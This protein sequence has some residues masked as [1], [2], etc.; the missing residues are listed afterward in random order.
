MRVLIAPN[1][2]KNSLSAEEVA[3]VIKEG[4]VASPLDV[5]CICFPVG[6]GGDGTGKLLSYHLNAKWIQAEVADPLGRKITSGFG[7]VHQDKT[8]IIELAEA[9]GLKLLRPEELDPTKATTFG[10]GQLIKKALDLNARKVLLTLGGSA[11]IDGGAGILNALGAKFLDENNESIH[12]RPESFGRLKT[13]DLSS[14]DDRLRK[15]E[16]QI[17]AD[18]N[19]PITG[20]N[21]A[22]RI[23]GPQKGVR[24]DQLEQFESN[25]ERFVGL[26]EQITKTTISG[27]RGGGAA[28][29]VAGVLSAVMNGKIQSGSEA[30]LKLTNFEKVLKTVDVVITGEG[31]LDLQTFDG[32]APFAVAKLAEKNKVPVIGVAGRVAIE[33]M[34]P[35]FALFSIQKGPGDIEVA[36]AA[37][38]ENLLACSLNIG[39]LLAM[40]PKRRRSR[41]KA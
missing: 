20:A 36:I 37:T 6:D 5:D 18:V 25:L 27:V 11:T 17:F 8:A 24:T 1:A 32:K 26:A 13:I 38:R 34:S 39:T 7:F 16:M 40:K 12:I 2:F 10:T 9:S 33:K 3:E 35:F 30:F 22:V 15:C 4:L 23:F 19:N 41:N 21:G 28:G 14:L 31:S 29:G